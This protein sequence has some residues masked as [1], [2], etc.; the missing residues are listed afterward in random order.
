MDKDTAQPLRLEYAFENG[1]DQV[2]IQRP[3]GVSCKGNVLASMKGGQ[4]GIDSQGAAK[5]SD[6]SVYDM[7]QVQC[8]PGAKSAADCAGVYDNR[9]FPIQMQTN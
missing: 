9:Q 8:K 4:L 5:C 7:P 2:E 1:K 6:G 3:N